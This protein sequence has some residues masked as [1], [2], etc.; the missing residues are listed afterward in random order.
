MS[1]LLN[2][3]GGGW[4]WLAGIAAL[5]VALVASYFGGKKI[6]T[7][8]T[9]AKADV[10]KAEAKTEVIKAS[11]EHESKVINNADTAKSETANLTDDELRQRMHDRWTEQDK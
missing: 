7:V 10:D 11:A 5:L 3:L 6:G 1:T 9:Q 8:Q 4:Q 2:L